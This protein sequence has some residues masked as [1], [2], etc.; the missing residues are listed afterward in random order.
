MKLLLAITAV[1]ATLALLIALATSYYPGQHASLALSFLVC[2][3]CI[4]DAHLLSLRFLHSVTAAVLFFLV[5]GL[6]QPALSIEL[7]T[8]GARGGISVRLQMP[9]FWSL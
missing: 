6:P 4:G 7:S 8:V 3:L 2:D 5:V 1:L 9:L